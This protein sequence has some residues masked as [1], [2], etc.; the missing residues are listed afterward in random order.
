[1]QLAAREHIGKMEMFQSSS[2]QKAGCNGQRHPAR[3]SHYRFQ[4][5][6]SQKAGCNPL[7]LRWM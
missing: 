4:S 3:S 2:S 5:S 1:M 6:S 7:E